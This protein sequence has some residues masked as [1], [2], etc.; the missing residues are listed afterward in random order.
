MTLLDEIV[1]WS[2]DRPSWQRDALRRLLLNGELSEEDVHELTEICK[3]AHGLAEQQEACPLTKEH[4]PEKIGGAAPVSLVSIFHHRGVNALAEDQTLKFAPGLTVVYGDNGAGKTGYIRILK[5]ACRARGQEEILGNVVSGTAPLAPVVAI[6]YR[7]GSEAE[8]HEW[9]PGSQNEVISRV[10]VFDTQCA[11][12]YLTE[13][14][15]VAFRPFGLDLFDK[16]V[17]ACKAVRA[18]LEAEQRA[19]ASNALAAVQA[20]IPEGTTVAKFVSGISS[21]TKPDAVQA[22]ARLTREEQTRLAFLE[23]S[24]LDLQAKDPDT[25]IRQLSVRRGRVQALVRHLKDAEAALSDEAVAAVFHARSEGR[26]KT[27]EAKRLREATFPH[28][29]LAGT[30]GEPWTALWESARK[31]SQESAYPG[32]EFPVVQDGAHCVLCQQNLDQAAGCRLKQFEAFVGSTTERKL[33]EVREGFER[34]RKSFTDLETTNEAVNETLN[35]IRIEQEAVADAIIAALD[36]NERRRLAVLAALEGEKYVVAGCPGAVT[37]SS[38]AEALAGQIEER[39]KTLRTDATHAVLQEMSAEAQELR[40]REVLKIH[41]QTVLDDIERR[42]KY[43]AYGLCIDATKTQ[44]ITQ[45][46][47][48]VTKTAVSQ[49]LKKSFSD[50]LLNLSFNHIEVELKELGG[51]DGVFYHQLVLKRAP[52]MDLKKVV[53]EGEQRCLCIAAFF[54]ELGTAD[55][56]SGIVF[57]DPV[58]SLDFQWRQSVARRL[59]QEA[60]TR[61]V[62]VFTHDVVFLLLLKQFADEK[63]VEQFDQHV[64]FL[65]NGAGVCAEELPW[66]ALPI[67]KKIGYLKNGCQAADKLARD[68]HQDAYEKEAK[69]LYGLLREGWERA[70]EEVLLSGVVERYRSSIQTQHVAQIAD[71]TAEDCKAVETAMSKCSKWLPGH[72]QAAAARAPVPSPTELKADIDALEEWVTAIRKRR[73]NRSAKPASA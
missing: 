8:V 68:G 7:V 3:S 50:E 24:L 52:G 28:G 6:K 45:K 1:E 48:A 22:L 11:A 4:V 64:R 21:L 15:D 51:A 59:V 47:T 65:Y 9:T 14:T 12:V 57:D 63:G 18:N 32:K 39:I 60:K 42:K 33:R 49:R 41:Q 54:A 25:L 44:A 70:L 37:V 17:R 35:E 31:F 5:S 58:S 73:N 61:Q 71:I 19:L 56:P 2:T 69:Y 67:K 29:M 62:I 27:E 23:R 16:L 26:R 36:T 40:A 30:G 55:D 72:D 38:E 34:H 10:S 20:H 66:V 46:S 13:K 43:A 53:S